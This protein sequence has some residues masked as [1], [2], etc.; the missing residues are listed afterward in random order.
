MFKRMIKEPVDSCSKSPVTLVFHRPG[1]L[2]PCF[3][4]AAGKSF[5]LYNRHAFD[6]SYRGSFYTT[7]GCIKTKAFTP[8]FAHWNISD[9][10]KLKVGRWIHV[11]RFNGQFQSAAMGIS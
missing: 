8:K 3:F 2:L 9:C 6:V 4:G 10:S 5:G 11:I 1:I 7:E